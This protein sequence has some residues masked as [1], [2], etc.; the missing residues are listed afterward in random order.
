MKHLKVFVVLLIVILLPNLA[1][2]QM[3]VFDVASYT[4][5]VAEYNQMLNQAMLLQQQANYLHQEL[6]TLNSN[7]YQWSNA[8]SLINQLGNV[9]NQGNSLSYNAQNI[10]QQ[11]Q[12]QFPGYQSPQNF[13]QQYQQNINSTMNT[14]NGVLQT[15]GMS[16]QD[17]TNENSRLAFLQNQVT[18]AQGQTQ[19]IQASAQISS[20]M[21]SQLQLLRQTMIAQTNAQTAY[22]A[23][24]LQ[25]QASSE[26]QVNSV[27]N[28]GSTTV[29][30]YGSSGNYL[31]IP[32]F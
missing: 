22:Y 1:F 17:F 28:A 26:A 4:K 25:N 18:S 23:Q 30:A 15:V 6:S 8:Q 32:N 10:S 11:F 13:N 2:A 20:E 21:D 12:Q 31:T 5:L 19:A 3:A 14:L 7:Q 24:Q 27:I 29:P 9:V 16:A